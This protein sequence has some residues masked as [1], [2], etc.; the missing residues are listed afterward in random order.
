MKRFVFTVALSVVLACS[1]FAKSD[2]VA[3]LRDTGRAFAQIAKEATPAV[4]SIRVEQTVDQQMPSGFPFEFFFGPQF[5]QQ[6]PQQ[7]R[8]I[9]QGSGFIISE[10]GYILTNNHVVNDADSIQ[11]TLKDGREFDAEL[12]GTDPETEIALIRIDG[13]NLP[14]VELGDSDDLEVGEWAIAVGNPFGLQETVTVGIISATGRSEV[15]ITDYE[16]FI[17]TDAAINPGNSGGPLLNI[18]GKVIGINTAIYSRSGGYMGIGFAIPINMALE[19]KD[20]LIKEGRVQRS[21]IGV[22]LQRI[23]PELAESF[24]LKNTEGILITQVAEDSAAAEAGIAAGDIIVGFNNQPVG[25]L[26][27]F[28]NRIAALPPGTEV[29][30]TILR[31]GEQKEI[32]LVTRAKDNAVAAAGGSFSI[33]KKAGFDVEELNSETILRLQLPAN[34]TGML[35]TE[36]QDGGPAWRSGLRAGMIIR[37][38]NRIPTTTANEFHKALQSV[39]GSNNLLL[40]VQIPRHGARYI[41]VKLN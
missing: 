36:V 18:D 12:V 32:K 1:G 41:V 31:N 17:Q 33:L 40:L 37:S 26:A 11:V 15:G 25:K 7:R 10:D 21:M 16:N 6:I 14:T 35:V 28:R 19:I 4:V 8:Q 39:Q 5:R 20:A 27:R 34:V 9:G 2:D 23:T 29:T 13:K 22:Y 3:T 24:G 38:V 30:L